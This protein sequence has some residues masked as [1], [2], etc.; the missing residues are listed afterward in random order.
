MEINNLDSK[1]S[2]YR[3]LNS[4]QATGFSR[5]LDICRTH[6][7]NSNI[8]SSD[9]KE[10]IV[11]NDSNNLENAF[12]SV[13]ASLTLTGMINLVQVTSKI[14]KIDDDFITSSCI[15]DFLINII[16]GD[17]DGL[18]K[19]AK[20]MI[21]YL[22]AKSEN[23]RKMFLNLD[24]ASFLISL[25][26]SE[27]KEDVKIGVLLIRELSYL[28]D[29]VF[30]LLKSGIFKITIGKI[31]YIIENDK[32]FAN[33]NEILQY[34]FMS[35]QKFKKKDL[36]EIANDIYETII[37]V[38]SNENVS[39]KTIELI[40]K[41]LILMI[42]KH[43]YNAVIQSGCFVLAMK[44]FNNQE[45]FIELQN[46]LVLLVSEMLYSS[47]EEDIDCVLNYIPINF[48]IDLFDSFD[49]QKLNFLHLI[50]FFANFV[51]LSE[52][53]V[54]ILTTDERLDKLFSYLVC[55]DKQEFKIQQIVV[56]CLWN[57]LRYG[58]V[59][60]TIKILSHEYIEDFI[61]STFDSDDIDFIRSVLIPSL[62]ILI[63]KLTNTM[64][65]LPDVI[66]NSIQERL[67]DLCY[68][69]DSPE[70]E[71]LAASC[72]KRI[73]PERYENEGFC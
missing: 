15:F 66:T 36:E 54:S 39:C 17:D 33:L 24:P 72:L 69:E 59:E 49:P 31:H 6:L 51:T 58:S 44:I 22:C 71:S 53:N 67:V 19:E 46:C 43:D 10:E 37:L 42:K 40:L 57:M 1:K 11:Q 26:E 30:Y 70:I 29:G 60:D 7:N 48:L 52:K 2:D 61:D 9:N 25:T 18:K 63:P 14:R 3:I 20:K 23:G 27:A 73:F 55:S 68:K 13:S 34:L 21:F 5:D 32:T 50:T 65:E 12:N 45:L 47:S 41:I 35:I 16:N 28:Q 38:L 62:L 4:S 8:N 56:W 64:S